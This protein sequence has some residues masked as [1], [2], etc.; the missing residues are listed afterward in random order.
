MVLRVENLVKYMPGQSTK[1]PLL[2][3]ISF[4][5]NRGESLALTGESGSG[6]S[7]MLHLI[8]ALDVFDQGEIYIEDTAVS[9]LTEAGR[10]DLRKLDISIV[11]QQFNIIPSLSVAQ[12]ISLH[13]K[14]AQRYDRDWETHV[15]Q[16]LG[17]VE[18]LQR[19]PEQL[20]GGQQQR[21]AIARAL[22]MKPKLLLADE[23]TGNLDEASSDRVLQLMM[24][25]IE[26][27]QTTLFCVTHS[28][29]I[30]DRL[31]QH[32]HLSNGHVT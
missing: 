8:A 25:L 26:D 3:G 28:L 30:A 31:Q 1:N 9:Q 15:S 14:L 24:E 23:P 12:N 5:L 6:K 16:R 2:D 13:A 22:V 27:S 4:T 7:T 17:L 19:Y 20:S 18:C 32:L 29:Q 21:V 11:F 10:S